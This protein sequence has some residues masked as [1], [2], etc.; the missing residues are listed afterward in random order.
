[1]MKIEK[2]EDRNWQESGSLYIAMDQNF[3]TYHISMKG[4]GKEGPVEFMQEDVER[5]LKGTEMPSG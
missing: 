4:K 1:M 3:S 2:K 5:A